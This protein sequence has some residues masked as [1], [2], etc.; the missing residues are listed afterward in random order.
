MAKKHHT[1]T[2]NYSIDNNPVADGRVGTH[3]PRRNYW[4]NLYDEDI[5][6][7]ERVVNIYYDYSDYD[8]EDS[9]DTYYNNERYD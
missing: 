6:D 2:R 9:G 4:G 8:P 7:E 3:K 1:T 5:Y